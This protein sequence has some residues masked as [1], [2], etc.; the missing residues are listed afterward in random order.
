VDDLY[1]A[2][3]N[4]ER[5]TGDRFRLLSSQAPNGLEK[6]SLRGAGTQKKQATKHYSKQ[7]WQ[8]HPVRSLSRDRLNK[9]PKKSAGY[10]SR[11]GPCAL[12]QVRAGTGTGA[13]G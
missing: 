1:H 7:K 11:Q 9:L 6:R 12:A 4:L 3:M 8:T 13:F 5:R 10:L 2:A